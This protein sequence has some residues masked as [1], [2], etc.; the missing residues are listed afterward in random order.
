MAELWM[1]NDCSSDDGPLVEPLWITL[2]T[3]P[4]MKRDPD[5]F[6]AMRSRLTFEPF[7]SSRLRENSVIC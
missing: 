4:D 7:E 2:P 1:G 3:L 6:D 5:L